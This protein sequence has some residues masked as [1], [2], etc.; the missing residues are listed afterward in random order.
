MFIQM[1]SRSLGQVLL[2]EKPAKAHAVPLPVPSENVG[3][4]LPVTPSTGTDT[5][6][7]PSSPPPTPHTS[8]PTPTRSSSPTQNIRRSRP[9]GADRPLN[10][11]GDDGGA[12]HCCA[13]AGPPPGGPSALA[14]D[15]HGKRLQQVPMALPTS[16]GVTPRV[17]RANK[18]LRQGPNDAPPRRI[19]PEIKAQPGNTTSAKREPRSGTMCNASRHVAGQQERAA[20]SAPAACAAHVHDQPRGKGKQHAAKDEGGAR[21]EGERGDG[22]VRVVCMSPSVHRC[23]KGL[24]HQPHNRANTRRHVES[25]NIQGN[26]CDGKMIEKTWSSAPELKA[27]F[28]VWA[29][30]NTRALHLLSRAILT[31]HQ[32]LVARDCRRRDISARRRKQSNSGWSTQRDI[33]CQSLHDSRPGP[34]GSRAFGLVPGS[35]NAV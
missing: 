13:E 6:A 16:P 17:L 33:R 9:G 15:P 19:T 8:R 20:C 26:A 27:N 32:A 22:D 3:F 10:N 12:A 28:N 18:H 5:K 30:V 35:R 21:R 14:N 11:D 29:A 1:I 7:R 34:K 23:K 4:W 24:R 31:P 2:H 25:R